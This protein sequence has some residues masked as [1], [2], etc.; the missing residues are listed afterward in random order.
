M[1]EVWLFDGTLVRILLRARSAATRTRRLAARLD[2]AGVD[3]AAPAAG[4]Q[5]GVVNVNGE[6]IARHSPRPL[7]DHA[8]LKVIR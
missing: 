1:R 3:A 5:C 2:V 8:H 6:S 4:E 7:L